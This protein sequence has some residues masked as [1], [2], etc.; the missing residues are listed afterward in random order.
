MDE[1]KLYYLKRNIVGEPTMSKHLSGKYDTIINMDDL[2]DA[3]GI[4]VDMKICI[5]GFR[6]KA[7]NVQIEELGGTIQSGVSGKTDILVTNNPNST[8]G[9]AKKARE[10][11]VKIMGIDEFKEMINV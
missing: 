10:L 1:N 3:D 4:L 6:D 2:F 5:T 11:G 7:L 9:K 8:S